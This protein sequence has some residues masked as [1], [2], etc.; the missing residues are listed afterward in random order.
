MR[1]LNI[2]VRLA[3]VVLPTVGLAGLSLLIQGAIAKLPNHINEKLPYWCFIVVL[4]L[5][6]F[7]A[8]CI[9]VWVFQ[10]FRSMLL[11]AYTYKSIRNRIF[12]GG[13]IL[14]FIMIIA[15]MLLMYLEPWILDHLNGWGGVYALAISVFIGG[16]WSFQLILLSFGLTGVVQVMNEY[17]QQR[18]DKV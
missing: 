2:T 17:M 10:R 13:G 16:A 6:L 12:W 5:A 3:A 1:D 7:F 8:A 9:W 11:G 14:S 15:P 4:V 18:I